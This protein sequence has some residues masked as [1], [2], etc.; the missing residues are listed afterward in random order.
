MS[1]DA[2]SHEF[3][4]SNPFQYES[5]FPG[6]VIHR[7]RRKWIHQHSVLIGQIS[8]ELRE[9][10]PGLRHVALEPVALPFRKSSLLL[11]A[12]SRT[13]KDEVSDDRA[14]PSRS[15][16]IETKTLKIPVR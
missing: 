13:D 6:F 9:G 8:D 14:T 7:I 12:V 10:W 11:I 16:E 3:S 5:F 1:R 2:F 15:R 4:M